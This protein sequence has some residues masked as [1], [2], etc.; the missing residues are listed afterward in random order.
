MN[1]APNTAVVAFAPFIAMA[2]SRNFIVI[3]RQKQLYYESS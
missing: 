3:K 2:I 1:F